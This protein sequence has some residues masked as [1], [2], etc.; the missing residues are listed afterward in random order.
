MSQHQSGIL[1]EHSRFAIWLEAG[2]QGD[3]NAVRR[4][5]KPSINS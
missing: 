1:I 2:V 3:L 5:S 4:A